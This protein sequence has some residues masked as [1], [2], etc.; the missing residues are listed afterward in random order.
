LAIGPTDSYIH[1]NHFSGDPEAAYIYSLKR[2]EIM[3]NY[4]IGK[5]VVRQVRGSILSA[6]VKGAIILALPLLLFAPGAVAQDSASV[7]G[8]VTDSG[9]ATVPQ[10]KVTIT[11]VNTNIERT[12]QTSRSSSHQTSLWRWEKM[13]VLT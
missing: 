2:D 12:A 8:V 9:G 4:E 5:I 6:R 7:R 11:D 3:K 1:T 10:A 13:P